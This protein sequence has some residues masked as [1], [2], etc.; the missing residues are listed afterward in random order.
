V[1]IARFHR[2]VSSGQI[3]QKFVRLDGQSLTRTLDR[4]IV[5]HECDYDAFRGPRLSLNWHG[6]GPLGEMTLVEKRA[7]QPLALD[8]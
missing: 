5:G 3:F 6:N 7:V 2:A 1:S 8:P 4:A